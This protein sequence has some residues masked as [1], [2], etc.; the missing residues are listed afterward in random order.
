GA[1]RLYVEHWHNSTD[2]S[3]TTMTISTVVDGVTTLQT[4]SPAGSLL[5][6]LYADLPNCATNSVSFAAC[7]DANTNNDWVIY[8]FAGALPGSVV[9]ITVISG[10][11]E[12]TQD[13]DGTMYPASTGDFTIPT[14]VEPNALPD[15]TMCGGIASTPITFPFTQNVNI[16][17]SND[18]P[19]IGL[20]A[21]GTGDVGSFVPTIGTSP[22]VANIE[23]ID[24]CFIDTFQ[25]NILPAP[26]PILVI[27]SASTAVPTATSCVYDSVNINGSGSTMLAPETITNYAWDFGDGNTSSNI[28][29]TH[30]YN[31]A[32]TY[33]LTLSLTGSNGCINSATT[34]YVVYPKPVAAFSTNTACEGLA[35]LFNG[36]ISTVAAPS[37]IANQIW[38]YGDG[39]QAVAIDPSYTYGSQGTYTAQLI[40]LTDQSCRDTTTNTVTVFPTPI[41]VA[42]IDNFC[43]Y[44]S[45][46]FFSN[47]SSIVAPGVIAGYTW[48]FGDGTNSGLNNPK[49]LYGTA[50]VYNVSLTA[51]S[52]DGCTNEIT[53]MAEAY[54]IPTPLFT[55]SDVC[56]YDAVAFDAT[57]SNI[58]SGAITDYTWSFGDGRNGTSA[59]TTNL[60]ALEGTYNVELIVNSNNNCK[61]TVSEDVTIFP[62]PVAAFVFNDECLGEAINFSSATTSIPN[63]GVIAN[64]SWS[65]GDGNTSTSTNP[66]HLYG[67]A[68]SYAVRLSVS[69]TD[70]CINEIIT[71]ATTH[72][73]PIA[74]FTFN[75]RCTYDL[76]TFDAT[77]SSVANGGTV[78]NYAWRF[79]D[80]NTGSGVTAS[81]LYSVDGT[82]NVELIT[83]SDNNCLDTTQSIATVFPVPT[84]EFSFLNQC[85]NLPISFY[86]GSS[87]VNNPDSIVTYTWDFAGTTAT[88]S[89]T[90]REFTFATVDT[91]LVQLTVST[92]KNCSHDTSAL[93]IVHPLPSPSFTFGKVCEETP[94]TF[95]N[96]TSIST[97]S[98]IGYSW[99]FGN[100]TTSNLQNPIATYNSA[101]PF[102]VNLIATSVNRCEAAI[103]IPIQVNPRP[104]ANFGNSFPESCS[105]L[106]I[107]FSDS[108][109]SNAASIIQYSWSFSDGNNSSSQNVNSC[110]INNDN[111]V[112]DIF[113]LLPKLTVTN[114]LGCV[115]SLEKSLMV[116]IFHNPYSSFDPVP[117]ETNMHDAKIQF[118]NYSLG[119]DIYKWYFADGDSSTL[120]EPLHHY[121]DTGTYVVKLFNYTVNG[122]IDSSEK[123][124][125][126][127]PVI[128]F[129]IPNAFTPDGDGLNDFFNWKGYG[130]KET[131][132]EFYIFN[133]WGEM[134]FKATDFTPWDGY[135]GSRPAQQDVYVYKIYYQDVFDE[136]H[137]LTG[138]VTLIR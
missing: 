67:A 30:L 25:I 13:C 43:V 109:S 138:T 113:D 66:P 89:G 87:A 76:F 48:D 106:C 103:T 32:G 93:A 53:S 19:G 18:N 58:S 90:I 17:W 71:T 131:D 21:S 65:F 16:N 15:F 9:N 120:F 97:G 95:T 28:N 57:T 119:T 130:I 26:D 73:K 132:F 110:F 85:L 38:A 20:A 104:T 27:T 35:T 102:N 39:S 81:N 7:A 101:G 47:A 56:R 79:G 44:D 23:V 94:I 75:D 99:D 5:G 8:D 137:K 105:P 123:P 135:A 100:S 84:A 78:A 14:I 50:G 11:N 64:Y 117:S 6:V 112:D 133:R 128:H 108:S 2:P 74:A 68:A 121:K 91:F 24:G 98:I 42:A 70:G 49:H 72:P 37:N 34:P 96:T 22:Q 54:P 86:A 55:F 40:V 82:Y 129:T 111:E 29:N 126:I 92:S 1:L 61:D 124:V 12:F 83:T 116:S 80:G 115:D 114:D 60:Y 4:A 52:T 69:S 33:N 45:L 122:C 118:E 36:G 63:P 46:A 41:A 10:N 77:I 134:I 127:T 62:V 136:K 59:N 88:S 125:T 3:T 51:T 31:I 107:D